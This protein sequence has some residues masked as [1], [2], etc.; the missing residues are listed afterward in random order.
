M[1]NWQGNNKIH[2]DEGYCFDVDN[3][4]FEC[5]VCEVTRQTEDEIRKH[6][7]DNHGKCLV[8]GGS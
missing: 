4:R 5:E 3:D 1:A 8:R 2:I 7:Q 6:M